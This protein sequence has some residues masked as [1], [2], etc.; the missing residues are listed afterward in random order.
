MRAGTLLVPFTGKRGR[1]GRKRA[2]V[3]K[4]KNSELPWEQGKNVC[5]QT[6]AFSS[7]KGE[8]ERGTMPAAEKEASTSTEGGE[9]QP[10]THS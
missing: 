8:S 10:R 6:G 3:A 4:E 2:A 7:D 9:T 1:E 5:H